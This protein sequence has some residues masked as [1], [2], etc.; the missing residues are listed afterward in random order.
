MERDVVDPL[1][2]PQWA[3]PWFAPW[4]CV[5]EPLWRQRA[6]T[7]G[8]VARALEAQAPAGLPVRFAPQSV[9]PPGTAY[10][11]H[12]FQQRSVPTRDNLHDAFNGLVWLRLPRAKARLN[13]LQAAEL[14]RAGIGATR[15]PVRDAATV[16]DENALL[17]HAPDALWQAL[18]QR[19]WQT[20]FGPL[21]PL[22]REARLL[23]FGHAALEKLVAPYKSI[24]V[25]AWR[26]APAFEPAGD[27]RALDDWLAR[28]LTPERLAAKPFAPL[29]LLGVPG[30]WP[31][32]EAPGF[33]EDAQVFR[34]ARGQVR[35]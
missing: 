21:R 12:I 22:W 17:L 10:E 23:V 29:P 28:D 14:A 3:A 19:R 6:P 34:P 8:A 7:P 4:R 20:L 32:N 27:L 2:Q 25:H 11:T 35:P 1:A 13:A 18:R 16:F 9:L 15:G 26:V 30:W 33:Y 31:A 5:G 24:T